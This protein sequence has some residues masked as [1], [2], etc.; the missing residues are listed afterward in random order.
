MLKKLMMLVVVLAVAVP[1]I[2]Q[3][4]DY[5]SAQSDSTGDISLSFSVQQSGDNSDQCVTPQQFGN[6]GSDQNGQAVLQYVS[7]SG[8]IEPSGD[9]F[10]FAPAETAPCTQQVQQSAAASG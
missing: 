3:E 10:S 9:A 2:G 7:T 8:K 1:A 6:A 4:V 5:S